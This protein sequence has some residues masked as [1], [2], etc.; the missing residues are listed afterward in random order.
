MAP[1]VS[2]G[3]MEKDR[4]WS[5]GEANQ[6][7]GGDTCHVVTEVALCQGLHSSFLGKQTQS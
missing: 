2:S 5:D 4:G 6:R 7:S 3:I 1:M